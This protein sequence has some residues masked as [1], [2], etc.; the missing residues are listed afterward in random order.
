M[1]TVQELDASY[2][3]RLH[4][5]LDDD[6]W[7]GDLGGLGSAGRLG[8]GLGDRDRSADPALI[9]RGAWPTR[10][11]AGLV[12]LLLLTGC[13]SVAVDDA[14]Y[15]EKAKMTTE[16]ATSELRTSELAA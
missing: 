15:T 5:G 7:T 11:S 12:L 4:E 8:G 6:R 13:V 16:D 14:S 1:I 3:R 10:V 2:G 9:I